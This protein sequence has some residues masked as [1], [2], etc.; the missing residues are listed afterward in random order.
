MERLEGPAMYAVPPPR[1]R[2][3]KVCWLWTHTGQV[4]IWTHLE[5]QHRNMVV[6]EDVRHSKEMD[7]PTV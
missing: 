4:L 2:K 1:G 5:T 3:A 7:G 6:S